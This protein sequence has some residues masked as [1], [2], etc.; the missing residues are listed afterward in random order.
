[1]VKKGQKNVY[2]NIECPLTQKLWLLFV[3]A[4]LNIVRNKRKK[5]HRLFTYFIG[6]MS[7]V[8]VSLLGKRFSSLF[9]QAL[10]YIIGHCLIMSAWNVEMLLIGR[11]FCG[12]CQGFCN[13]LTIIYVLELCQSLKAKAICGVLL[14]LVGNAGT[15]ITYTIG[16]VPKV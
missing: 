5:S 12:L 11:F 15:L 13:C 6:L 2:V 7:S 9:G 3:D 10:S 4:V 16:K 8:L 1:M 14:S